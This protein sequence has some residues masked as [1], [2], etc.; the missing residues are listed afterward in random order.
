MLEQETEKKAV[1]SESIPASAEIASTSFSTSTTSS[2]DG[3]KDESDD[4]EDT[5]QGES[6]SENV[7]KAPFDPP[8]A[9][10]VD[11]EAAVAEHAA[12]ILAEELAA[13]AKEWEIIHTAPVYRNRT[14]F[15]FGMSIANLQ[16]K[17]SR[18]SGKLE[19]GTTSGNGDWKV[20]FPA[21]DLS[22]VC[23]VDDELQ[24]WTRS[25]GK[26]TYLTNSIKDARAWVQQMTVLPSCTLLKNVRA[27]PDERRMDDFGLGDII[28]FR[29]NQPIAGLQRAFTS[30]PW[31]HTGIVVPS[32]WGMSYPCGLS[33]DEEPWML[34]EATPDGVISCPLAARI[35]QYRK[36]A[37]ARACVRQLR[38]AKNWDR[39]M[40]RHIQGN[41]HHFVT[42]CL[43][44]PYSYSKV[45]RIPSKPYEY[46]RA[47]EEVESE[48]GYFCSELCVRALVSMGVF[49]K[50]KY[51]HPNSYWPKSFVYGQEVDRHMDDRFI[52]TPELAIDLD[53]NYI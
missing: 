53:Q 41:L 7:E 17:R 39:P 14:A 19:L 36:D 10:P 33:P 18:Y 45:M 3:E 4:E 44:A 46:I 13:E 30:S 16:A 22:A 50:T 29:I 40:M 42:S 51:V 43:G 28:M 12:K 6:D 31:D 15:T 35:N 8:Q 37:G 27:W 9:A 52:F 24:I 25:K 5:L 49:D 20:L 26:I 2:Q 38:Y 48:Q 23:C 11:R 21:D 47:E 32:A 1:V 34:L